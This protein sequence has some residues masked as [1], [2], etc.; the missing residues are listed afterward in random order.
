MTETVTID[1]PAVAKPVSRP[2]S[3]K[4]ATVSASALAR[5]LDCSRTYIG[6]LEAE[7]VISGKVT[8]SRSIRAVLP[9]CDACG[10]SGGNRRALRR[11][12][13]FIGRSP[14]GSGSALPRSDGT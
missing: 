6:K 13:I 11:T 12:L 1:R 5:H 14:N 3:R 9:T 4:P 10:T 7:G 8:A 2:R